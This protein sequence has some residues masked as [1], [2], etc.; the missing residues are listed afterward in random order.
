MESGVMHHLSH[1]ST[2][3]INQCDFLRDTEVLTARALHY[4]YAHITIKYQYLQKNFA[5]STILFHVSL[6]GFNV[7]LFTQRHGYLELLASSCSTDTVEKPN[8]T[9]TVIVEEEVEENNG[10]NGGPR[11]QHTVNT[12]T[13]AFSPLPPRALSSSSAASFTRL[14]LVH[15][16]KTG[17]TAL[18]GLLPKP[19]YP[20][21]FA[22]TK[23]DFILE[24]Y[25]I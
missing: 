13:P 19:M 5:F 2:D 21:E 4:I 22:I 23:T 11:R 10:G 20:G 16:P 7:S 17:G 6:F 12:A 15:I 25:S 9:V 8:A 3:T 1:K 14:E 24:G 18:E